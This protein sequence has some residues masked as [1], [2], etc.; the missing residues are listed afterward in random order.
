[1]MTR[2]LTPALRDSIEEIDKLLFDAEIL[3]LGANTRTRREEADRKIV[4]ARVKL[5]HLRD[6]LV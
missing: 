6:R 3:V 1:M 4:D 5:Q 2:S